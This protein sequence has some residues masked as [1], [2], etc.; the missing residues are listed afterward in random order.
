M[1]NISARV[2]RV[3]HGQACGFQGCVRPT[4]YWAGNSPSCVY[5]YRKWRKSNSI[6]IIRGCVSCGKSFPANGKKKFTCSPECSN[7]WKN[8]HRRRLKCIDGGA[9]KLSLLQKLNRS[10]DKNKQRQRDYDRS[11]Y[12]TPEKL[13]K[14]K[15]RWKAYAS[16]PE[17]KAAKKITDHIRNTSANG[18]L[19]IRQQNH[20]RRAIV[21]RNG[22]EEYNV[23]DIFK[24]DKFI[25][26]ICHKKVS[27]KQKWP[28]PLSA[29]IDHIVPVSSGGPDAP[30]N[31]QT[32]HLRCNLVKHV[33]AL[34]QLFF[35][36]FG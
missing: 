34:G 3:A 21:H 27:K 36:G 15:A 22:F 35:E 31:I 2:N 6:T 30:H 1:K 17:R 4:K 8:D 10:L 11:R 12:G 5:H 24:R 25:C 20:K 23:A 32:T 19:R 29:S 18:R 26:Q 16:R 33:R 14:E 28:H 13:E 7:K 9:E